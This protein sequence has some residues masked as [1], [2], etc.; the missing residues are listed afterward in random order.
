MNA[1]YCVL[2]DISVSSSV[3][4]TDQ[5][6]DRSGWTTLSVPVMKHTLCSAAMRDGDITT[7]LT[8]KTS[9]YGVR[10]TPH[11]NT[12]VRNY[13][14]VVPVAYAVFNVATVT[15]QQIRWILSD[16]AFSICHVEVVI[17]RMNTHDLNH[18][19]LRETSCK[20]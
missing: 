17:F 6:V 20:M 14:V 8:L 15:I 2:L 3:T 16:A 7:V 11:S 4:V 18:V 12:Q 9:Q 13:V 1:D 5:A 19:H 10:K